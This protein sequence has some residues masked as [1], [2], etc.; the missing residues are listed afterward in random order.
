MTLYIISLEFFKL[1]SPQASLTFSKLSE[2]SKLQD[3]MSAPEPY[4]P[5][6]A[7]AVASQYNED[8]EKFKKIAQHCT[9]KYAGAKSSKLNVASYDDHVEKVIAMGLSEDEAIKS[10]S[11]SNF[12][13]QATIEEIN[14]WRVPPKRRKLSHFTGRNF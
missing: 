4:K 14:E 11:N 1:R 6:D 9:N 13:L 12:D 8:L 3:L 5:Q 7:R 10:L 2:K